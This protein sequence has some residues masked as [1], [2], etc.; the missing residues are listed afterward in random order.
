[1]AGHQLDSSGSEQFDRARRLLADQR[2]DEALDW[3]EIAIDT[4]A[5]LQVKA[6]AAAYVAALLLGFGRP[7]EVAGF[8]AVIRDSDGSE[9]LA[10]M[11]EAAACVQL[12]DARGALEL[13][14]DAG[15]PVVT[16]TDR[17][18][19]CSTAGV[20]ATRVRALALAGRVDDARR[21]LARAIAGAGAVP[22]EIWESVAWLAAEGLVDARDYAGHLDVDSA[23]EL[24]GRLASTSAEGLDA[25]AE[26]MWERTPGDPRVLAAAT[27][28]GARLDPRRAL[29]WSL[30]LLEAGVPGRSPVLERAEGAYV[31]PSDRARAA[32]VAAPLDDARARRALEAAVDAVDD[33]AVVALLDD[34]LDAGTGIA[35]SLVVAA[36]TT[37]VRCLRLATRLCERGHEREA[38]AVLVAGLSLPQ[39][40]ALTPSE[41]DALVPERQRAVLAEVARSAADDEVAAILL[42]VP[43]A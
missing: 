31:A 5:L 15:T 25:I 11:L 6:S 19:P 27:V 35:D 23:V 14:G 37:T 13:V 26:A 30:R 3:F 39:A 20:Q 32:I 8:A 4:T 36:A 43:T 7:W 18:F 33:D 21:E 24:F 1:V 42:S 22:T 9:P 17:W 40:D 10:A 41:F 12:G 28:F 29:E 16:P 2:E 34:A 38:F